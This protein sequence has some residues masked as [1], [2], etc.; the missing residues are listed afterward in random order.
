MPVEEKRRMKTGREKLASHFL[1]QLNWK[2]EVFRFNLRPHPR[3]QA[4]AKAT[5]IHHCYVDEADSFFLLHDAS[6]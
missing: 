4:S 1:K 5:R 6:S 2:M 3:R